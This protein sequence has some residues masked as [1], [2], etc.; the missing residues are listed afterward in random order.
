MDTT[1]VRGASD[2]R[3]AEAL[4]TA[5][6]V[7]DT[8]PEES[9]QIVSDAQLNN[10]FS[11]IQAYYQNTRLHKDVGIHYKVLLVLAAL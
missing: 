6:D 1:P 5:L 4:I 11:R 8:G 2:K 3:L 10:P 9:W 7:F